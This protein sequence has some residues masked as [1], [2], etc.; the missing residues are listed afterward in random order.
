M[1]RTAPLSNP[2]HNATPNERRATVLGLAAVAL[3]STVAT[4]FKLGLRVLSPLE[5]LAAGALVSFVF[6]AVLAA[7]SGAWRQIPALDRK[8]HRRLLM[9]GL[10]N[11]AL[12]YLI[13]FEAYDRLPAQIAQ[14]LNYTWAITL[15]ILSVPILGQRLGVRQLTGIAISYA[16][17]AVLLGRGGATLA[18]AA[19]PLGVAL[20]LASTLVWAAYWLLGTRHGDNPIVA[21]AT[22][23]F[24]GCLAILALCLATAQLPPLNAHTLLYGGWVGMVE[25]GVTFLL[26][27]AALAASASAA[28]IGQLIF[29]SP[30]ASFVLIASVLGERIHPASIVALVLI[31][32]GLLIGQRSAAA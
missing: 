32:A 12:Y 13:L 10:L 8:A 7:V 19:E 29:I 25:M 15:A 14:P 26:W 6:F 5:L 9:L 24:W 2:V 21:M 1:L 16:G 17:V 31:V 4:G 23:F 28:R 27:R 11:P 18:P 22:S 3:W 30:F 20:A